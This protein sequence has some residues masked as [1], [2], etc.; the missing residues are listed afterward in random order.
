[1]TVHGPASLPLRTHDTATRLPSEK[2]RKIVA[3]VPLASE[4]GFDRE[5]YARDW[6]LIRTTPADKEG[7]LLGRLEL[8]R[9]Q[10]AA[11][12]RNPL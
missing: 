6:R 1:M 10:V 11:S 9:E 5:R 8:H 2:A 7:L 4:T 12:V 3:V